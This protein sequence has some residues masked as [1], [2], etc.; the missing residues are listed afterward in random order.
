MFDAVC[1][2]VVEGRSLADGQ[3]QPDSILGS[4]LRLVCWLLSANMMNV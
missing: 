3:G 2:G 1:R 4:F